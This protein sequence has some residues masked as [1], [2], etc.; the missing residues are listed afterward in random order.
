M[1]G[2]MSRFA[3]YLIK[4]CIGSALLVV[5]LGG[6]SLGE[7]GDIELQ[8]ANLFIQLA[9]DGHAT[10]ALLFLSKVIDA[11]MND[12]DSCIK[13]LEKLKEVLGLC[14]SV[15]TGILEILEKEI[16][17][18]LLRVERQI[19]SGE[20][21][22]KNANACPHDFPYLCR[23][24]LL[25]V[26]TSDF[27]SEK[28][29]VSASMFK[30]IEQ[31]AHTIVCFVN[32][33][34]RHRDASVS[35]L[36]QTLNAY[37]HLVSVSQR[38][39]V[40][41]LYL[42]ESS[43]HEHFFLLCLWLIFASTEDKITF[44]DQ[45]QGSIAISE[46]DLQ[47]VANRLLLL[48]E[49][50]ENIQ[51]LGIMTIV[52][53]I[54][55]TWR[56]S[57]DMLVSIIDSELIAKHLE[58]VTDNA[59]CES[60]SVP[61]IL[62]ALKSEDFA[63]DLH[64][65]QIYWFLIP[66]L[67]VQLN[68][69]DIVIPNIQGCNDILSDVA[70]DGCRQ[71]KILRPAKILQTNGSFEDVFEFILDNLKLCEES[72]GKW[73][74]RREKDDLS[75][76]SQHLRENRDEDIPPVIGNMQSHMW[77]LSNDVQQEIEDDV[78]Q[79]RHLVCT[80]YEPFDEKSVAETSAV[81]DHGEILQPQLKDHNFDE[82]I[83]GLRKSIIKT[84]MEALRSKYIALAALD[85][86]Q[87]E[88]FSASIAIFSQDQSNYLLADLVTLL[89][90]AIL[91]GR[92]PILGSSNVLELL[93]SLL[94]YKRLEM[95]RNRRNDIVSLA[96]K[97]LQGL[98]RGSP[99]EPSIGVRLLDI[100]LEPDSMLDTDNLEDFREILY[101]V[102]HLAGGNFDSNL[103]IILTNFDT[104]RF[105]TL[106]AQRTLETDH[107][108]FRTMASGSK[109]TQF[110][111]L[112]FDLAQWCMKYPVTSSVGV[113]ILEGI[114]SASVERYF[115]VCLLIV[116]SRQSFNG[117]PGIYSKLKEVAGLCQSTN[118]A[119]ESL[120][121]LSSTHPFDSSGDSLG[122]LSSLLKSPAFS[123]SVGSNA[124]QNSIGWTSSLA[125]DGEVS[126]NL[127]QL[128]KS[129]K[130]ALVEALN[131]FIEVY[132]NS[133][134]V[135][136][137]EYKIVVEQKLNSLL[138]SLQL[139]R[140][141][142]DHPAWGAPWVWRLYRDIMSPHI[143]NID[144]QY[145]NL[146]SDVL[147]SYWD[148][149]PWQLS[150]FH[151]DE[152]VGSLQ[153]IRSLISS[154]IFPLSL[155]LRADWSP[156]LEVVRDGKT[157]TLH[158][159]TVSE[160]GVVIMH[161]AISVPD[162][163]LPGWLLNEKG[164]LNTDFLQKISI[165]MDWK[166]IKDHIAPM[167]REKPHSWILSPIVSTIASGT[168]DEVS[169][170][171]KRTLLALSRAS[172]SPEMV[173]EF[174]DVV[175]QTLTDVLGFSLCSIVE[176]S[177]ASILPSQS[178][179][180]VVPDDIPLELLEGTME[181]EQ[182]KTQNASHKHLQ[183]SNAVELRSC[184][185]L[186]VS[187]HVDIVH[188]LVSMV[189]SALDEESMLK[190]HS[191]P[192][193]EQSQFRGSIIT[194][195]PSSS[196]F[197]TIYSKAADLTC[198]STVVEALLLALASD[199]IT[200]MTT[201]P[202]PFGSTD[203][204]WFTGDRLFT[205]LSDTDKMDRRYSLKRLLKG[206]SHIGGNDSHSAS[207]NTVNDMES[208]RICLYKIIEDECI[209]NDAPNFLSGLGYAS[210]REVLLCD[211]LEGIPHAHEFAEGIIR[212]VLVHTNPP[213]ISGNTIEEDNSIQMDAFYPDNVSI[214]RF[215][216]L[217]HTAAVTECPLL[218]TFLLKQAFHR[219]ATIEKSEWQ[220]TITKVLQTVKVGKKLT[221]ESVL[222]WLHLLD[223]LNDPRWRRLP[224]GSHNDSLNLFLKYLDA[225]VS[226]LQLAEC[227]KG[228]IGTKIA[229]KVSQNI[230][231]HLSSSQQEESSL[232]HV[233]S[234]IQNETHETHTIMERD[235]SGSLYE[236]PLASSHDMSEDEFASSSTTGTRRQK[237][238]KGFKA[239]GRQM[240]NIGNKITKAAGSQIKQ[241][242]TTLADRHHDANSTPAENPTPATQS[243][244]DG[245]DI[246]LNDVAPIGLA[247]YA[248]SAYIRTVMEPKLARRTRSADG[249]SM[250]HPTIRHIKGTSTLS[251]S[252]QMEEEQ[253]LELDTI[254]SARTELD[255]LSQL[256]NCSCVTQHAL[257]TE[258]FFDR[259]PQLLHVQVA[260]D[261]F[262]VGLISSL[263]TDP[264]SNRVFHLAFL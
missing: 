212:Q 116:S 85:L 167:R 36:V 240:S 233:E 108:T 102:C 201:K 4:T 74:K 140:L 235:G 202:V 252:R 232:A 93:E 256:K 22:P 86:Y 205:N 69:M 23:M 129:D 238:M 251:G 73:S 12:E 122:I 71:T 236:I 78:I 7:M 148:R 158:P 38:T 155:L 137:V 154:S 39:T 76:F 234:R 230:R 117:E 79:I 81:L 171:L 228:G 239:F 217:A 113:S 52:A 87:L 134:N 10:E 242:S 21:D 75:E 164:E 123:T 27:W 226:H 120:R 68:P 174:F 166:Y 192:I 61:N 254:L 136:G 262:K 249:G 179:K 104:N 170:R 211:S 24:L 92:S 59:T 109:T 200:L 182:I 186:S 124:S 213:P 215:L 258:P 245:F 241:P 209:Q 157:K 57:N 72:L 97:S 193:W 89:V 94:R 152:Q 5:M 139:P 208:L 42:R 55:C 125:P 163:Q 214:D 49:G 62:K 90:E 121:I 185:R 147:Q 17:E 204:P 106:A 246:H 110:I 259:M 58:R 231:Q 149:I 130:S 112:V 31:I 221:M 220:F 165:L 203:P 91:F 142:E 65:E 44:M 6:T 243:H 115:C 119:V 173:Q 216:R 184:F 227:S 56:H 160:C 218:S 88:Y 207:L 35:V 70:E 255:V 33:S 8:V 43:Q 146:G 162:W 210:L 219:C 29:H 229:R 132:L 260:V 188:S 177:S 9:S 143:R 133:S 244:D 196:N 168:K 15:G 32:A 34:G 47:D 100:L 118:V 169:I 197:T 263:I 198:G 264:M 84:T 138:S 225:V 77:S 66:E 37:R 46:N 156:F 199:P 26:S 40:F 153:E 45:D 253:L 41:E 64:A 159:S 181:M 189:Q 107:K 176:T 30:M 54:Y 103:S 135:S 178:D 80:K 237:V 190:N 195:D 223:W 150:S 96:A 206:I 18:R 98:G 95:D 99:L 180:M 145:D 51:S 101:H 151:L 50:I 247:A 114:L 67:S 222:L 83:K 172:C 1:L 60:S 175:F 187:D 48:Q 248:I 20:D 82:K 126:C 11:D 63:I 14:F 191:G 25:V 144:K 257:L 131:I 2:P 105:G 3:S 128:G 127:V 19:L 53:A 111:S 183:E 224:P 250:G 28:G 141:V 194:W 16:G 261:D 161:L 13:V